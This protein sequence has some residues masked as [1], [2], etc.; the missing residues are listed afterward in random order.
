MNTKTASVIVLLSFIALAMASN[1]GKSQADCGTNELYTNCGYC[2]GTC[3]DP[4]PVCVRMCQKPGC[5]CPKD[6]AR[7]KKG[8][9]IPVAKC[10]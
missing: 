8:K 9:C 10:T 6:F 7:N 3:S 5:Y 1:P 2:E 4:N